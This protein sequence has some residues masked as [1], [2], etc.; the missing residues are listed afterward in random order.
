MN[1]KYPVSIIIIEQISESFYEWN[2]VNHLIKL[3]V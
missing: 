2:L 1:R 3:I